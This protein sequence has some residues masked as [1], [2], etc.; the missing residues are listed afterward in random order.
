M[1]DC[2]GSTRQSRSYANV[3]FDTCDVKA[4]E[5]RNAYKTNTESVIILEM[6]KAQDAV[7][8][9]RVNQI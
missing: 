1:R 5:K 2:T 3:I 4:F 7:V 6:R 9:L 8:M